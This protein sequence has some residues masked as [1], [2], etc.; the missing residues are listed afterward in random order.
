MLSTAKL[1]LVLAWEQT[2]V[3]L[4]SGSAQHQ[5]GSCSPSYQSCMFSPHSKIVLFWSFLAKL[6]NLK[7]KKI[8]MSFSLQMLISNGQTFQFSRGNGAWK[9]KNCLF[10]II[11]LSNLFQ[12]D[13]IWKYIQ[14]HGLC[15]NLQIL[16]FFLFRFC[17]SNRFHKIPPK[18]CKNRF[19][20]KLLCG[21]LFYF[22]FWSFRMYITGVTN[23]FFLLLSKYRGILHIFGFCQEISLNFW[24]MS[25]WFFFSKM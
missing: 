12:I 20:T 7:F 3:R 16:T 17:I 14:N 10:A 13:S 1:L 23:T 11:S 9:R 8:L 22:V 21:N 4:D 2:T 15:W 25:A 18:N 5:G 6:E 19:F 24:K